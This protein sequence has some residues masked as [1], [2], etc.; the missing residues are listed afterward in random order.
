MG[1]QAPA[2]LDHSTHVGHSVLAIASTRPRLPQILILDLDRRVRQAEAG[3]H[4]PLCAKKS[5][6]GLSHIGH[7]QV[8][9]R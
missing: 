8:A 6:A 3:L 7:D 9:N 5:R 2:S 1:A 4:R